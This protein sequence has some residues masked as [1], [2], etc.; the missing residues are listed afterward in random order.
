[1]AELDW[2]AAEQALVLRVAE[3]YFDVA[4][5]AEALRVLQRQQQAVERSL[6]EA[7]DHFDRRCAGHRHAQGATTGAS[8]P[9]RCW[10]RSRS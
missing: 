7:R 5:A 2:R 10:P 6:A 4:L 9:P 3:R 1:M 8:M